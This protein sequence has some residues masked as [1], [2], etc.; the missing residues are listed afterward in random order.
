MV[1][2]L[3]LGVCLHSHRPFEPEED[4]F[5]PTAAVALLLPPTVLV[6]DVTAAAIENVLD[7]VAIVIIKQAATLIAF[8]DNAVAALALALAVVAS[9]VVV[10]EVPVALEKRHQLEH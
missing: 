2:V 1:V 8:A 5:A 10:M 9:S 6:D 4:L 3:L 7:D